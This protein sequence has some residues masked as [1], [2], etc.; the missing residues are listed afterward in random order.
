MGMKDIPV[1]FNAIKIE[2]VEK[3]WGRYD[4]N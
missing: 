4:H 1:G 3:V 2:G